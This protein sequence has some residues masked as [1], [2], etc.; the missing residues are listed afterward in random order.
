[1]KNC[2]TRNINKPENLYS[3]D[4]PSNR[5]G[6][7]NDTLTSFVS[8]ALKSSSGMGVMTSES[9]A[10]AGMIEK[11]N[12]EPNKH[13]F[14]HL[15]NKEER[16]RM[17]REKRDAEIEKRKREIEENL[18]RKAELRDRQLKER[19]KRIEELKHRENER[20]AR[21]EENRRQ[22]D[23]LIRVSKSFQNKIL[24]AL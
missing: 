7:S 22:R 23:E 19:Q 11:I 14:L 21:V 5:R 3:F 24:F 1:M 9:S 18:R 4:K 2:Q 6:Y 10:A 8:E 13:G 15:I 20:R 16:I 12:L 17:V